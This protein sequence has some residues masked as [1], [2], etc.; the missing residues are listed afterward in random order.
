M[1][2]YL[3]V[4]RRRNASTAAMLQMEGIVSN[5]K[6]SL[7]DLAAD[8]SLKDDD[9]LRHK[10]KRRSSAVWRKIDST[11]A[12]EFS[13]DSNKDMMVDAVLE[14]ADVNN[15]RSKKRRRLTLVDPSSTAPQ[16][17]KKKL[18]G[19]RV[20]EPA[21]R[22]VDDS[23]QQVAA[24]TR[25]VQEHVQFCTSHAISNWQ[26]WCNAELGNVL[27]AC[28]LW[29]DAEMAASIL[30]SS[31]QVEA[32]VGAVNGQ[33]QTPYQVA[34][35]VNHEPVCEVLEAFG[36]DDAF[37]VDMY[38]LEDD[39]NCTHEAMT[40]ELAGG[41]WDEDTGQ[42]VLEME[43]QILG[44]DDNDSAHQ[45]DDDDDDSNSE[46]W[47]GNDYPDD[48][49]SSSFE[50][51]TTFRDNEYAHDAAYGIYGQENEYHDEC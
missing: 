19:Y 45:D 28:A 48:D 29:N 10:K 3:R 9:D 17:Q 40:C 25:T 36:G 23:L 50:D 7:D 16:K 14:D 18:S 15:G 12:Q 2:Q 31:R 11:A 38:C 51:T 33:G 22:M 41:Y 8:L 20:L 46:N 5:N 32:L 43:N 21:E 1:P 13:A 44:S 6:R 49:D 26:N 34:R 30:S 27:H 47:Q 35:L 39:N 4:R 37:V 42:I 24:G